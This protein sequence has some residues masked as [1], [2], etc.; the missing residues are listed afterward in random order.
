MCG[1][2]GGMVGGCY[3]SEEPGPVLEPPDCTD[4]DGDGFGRGDACRGA[5]CDD[6]DPAVWDSCGPNCALEPRAAG[7]ACDALEPE[8]CYAGPDGTAGT[9][10]CAVGIRTC[11]GGIWTGCQGQVLPGTELCDGVDNDCDGSVDE[12]V[13]NA[14]GG[15]DADCRISCAGV[16]CDHDFDTN[17]G[18]ELA[19]DGAVVL[20]AGADLMPHEIWIPDGQVGEVV[21]VDTTNFSL[22]GTYRTG[23]N[24][25]SDAPAA[26]AVDSEGSAYVVNSRQGQGATTLVKIYASG[27]PDLDGDGRVETSTSDEPLRWGDDE[28]V[29]WHAEMEECVGGWGCGYGWNVVLTERG[30]VGW[31]SL[32]QLGRVVEFDADSGEL[33]GREVAAPSPVALVADA[34]GNV[35]VGTYSRVIQRFTADDPGD[36]DTY[37]LGSQ[38]WASSLDLGEDGNLIVSTPLGWFDP[39]TEETESTGWSTVD[40]VVDGAGAVWGAGGGRTLRRYDAGLADYDSFSLTNTPYQLAADR[41][42]HVW[43][44]QQWGGTAVVV[45]DD[46]SGDELA[47]AI[48][49][50]GANCLTAP[51][52]EGDPAG[53][54]YRRAFGGGVSEATAT[55]V[56]E[57]QCTW[58]DPSWDRLSWES[59]GG[60]IEIWARAADNPGLLERQSWT[61][62]GTTPPAAVSVDVP[63][64]GEGQ[65]AEIRAVLRG[66]GPRL[67]RVTMQWTCPSQGF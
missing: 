5:D 16:G 31:V 58:G 52:F 49:G 39:S 41:D 30:R 66:R 61:L 34:D 7:C 23:P 44:G 22:L 36:S 13:Q 33:T 53:L 21:R 28:C 40:A 9:G 50:C 11:R 26:V 54:R 4:H 35:W 14:C 24:Q 2:A 60:D 47:T 3:Q 48:D 43:A 62:V 38:T 45:V 15:C 8:L 32:Y 63:P 20:S 57:A 55:H 67:S 1:I 25:S 56:F 46:A 19:D 42:G 17:A 51:T 29:A 6:G 59:S 27:C 65:F 12:G 10:V 64:V 37:T 18:A